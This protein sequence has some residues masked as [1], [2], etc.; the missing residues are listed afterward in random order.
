M[1]PVAL[2][3]V[4]IDVILPL[5]LTLGGAAAFGYA[6]LYD[7]PGGGLQ[8]MTIHGT[9]WLISPRLGYRFRPTSFIDITPHLGATFADASLTEPISNCSYDADGNGN[10]TNGSASTSV[11]LVAISAEVVAAL[12]MTKTFNLL[13]GVSYDQVIA[14]SGSI[15]AS[16][17]NG[18]STSNPTDVSGRYL[19]AQ[20][21]FGRGGYVF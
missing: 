1:N 18:N 7:S 21:W 12:R 9:A 20:L 19:G 2:P 4:G 14:A 6:S 15:G 8:S 10:C 13:A 11:F 3:R 5:G 17:G 16:D